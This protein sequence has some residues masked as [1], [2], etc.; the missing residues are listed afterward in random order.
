M[1][2]NTTGYQPGSTTS[3]YSSIGGYPARS[4]S[5]RPLSKAHGGSRR[6][7]VNDPNPFEAEKKDLVKSILS[8]MSFKQMANHQGFKKMSTEAQCSMVHMSYEL[9]KDMDS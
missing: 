7:N 3:A 6:I 4:D 1:N 2:T 9:E 8:D 5:P